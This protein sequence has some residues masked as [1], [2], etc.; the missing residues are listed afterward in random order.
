MYSVSEWES[1]VMKINLQIM[2]LKAL[3]GNHQQDIKEL[4]EDRQTALNA[5]R[6]LKKHQ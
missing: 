4:Q 3:N 6:E 1:L 5:I 2:T